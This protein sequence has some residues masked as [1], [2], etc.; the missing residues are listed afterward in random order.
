MSTLRD[1]AQRVADGGDLPVALGDFLDAFYRQP[2]QASLAEEPAL[3]R[4][5]AGDGDIVDAYLGAIAERLARQYGFHPPAW[6]FSEERYLH[7][8]AFGSRSAALRATL[9]L[10][11]PVEFRS[12]NIFV[13]ANAL[14][15]AS[16]HAA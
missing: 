10:E 2:S 3:L 13:T 6:A 8:P 7:R 5:R 1:L 12:R 14:D 16:Q 15:R 11:S 9:L 4:G